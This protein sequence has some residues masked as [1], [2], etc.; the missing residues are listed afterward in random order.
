MDKPVVA[1]AL[2]VT[3]NV[4]PAMLSV[5][6]LEAPVVLAATLNATAPVPLPVAPEEIVIQ[7]A[8]LAAVQKQPDA[9]STL[10]EPLVALAGCV[11][12]EAERL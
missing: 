4:C 5:P 8:L 9:V 6:D 1:E 2:C 10:T 7:V 12:E 11:W 3:E